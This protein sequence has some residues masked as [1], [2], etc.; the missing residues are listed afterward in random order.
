MLAWSLFAHSVRL[1][2]N[3]LD[4][5]FRVSFVLYLVV[6][7]SQI[8]NLYVAEGDMVLGPD[9]N[10]YPMVSGG[11]ILLLFVLG[12]AGVVA[13]LWI[14]VAWHRFV[15]LSE[16]PEGWLPAW[17]PAG[18]LFGYLW[19]SIL[20]GLTVS[21]AVLPVVMVSFLLGPVVMLALGVG[22]GSY[23]FFRLS[24]ILPAIALGRDM[25]FREALEAT[26]PAGATLLGLAGL[27]IIG[28]LL[29]Q[30]PTILSGDPNSTISV[31]Y[32]IVVGWFATIIGISLLTTVYGHYVEGRGI[33]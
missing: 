20:V 4:V 23:V 10:T 5:A 15:L 14:A 8:A 31:I 30:L 12:I 27:M 7:A 26:K 24:P 22:V 13:S 17:P 2:L 19:R 28:S 18:S 1:V 9:G 33:D 6:A 3:N 16:V 11:D 32:S 25:S 21:L 29:L